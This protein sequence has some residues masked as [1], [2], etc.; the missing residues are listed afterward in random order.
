MFIQI[1]QSKYA[2][3]QRLLRLRDK[4]INKI[5]EITS[6]VDKLEK[7]QQNLDAEE[8]RPLPLI[9]HMHPEEL[10]EKYGILIICMCLCT[11]IR[12]QSF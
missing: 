11:D 6:L 2:F 8:T 1:H 4:K 3:N 12:R 7:V 10:P 5:D 9:P